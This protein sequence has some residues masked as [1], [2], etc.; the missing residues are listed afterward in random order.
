MIESVP[1]S[2]LFAAM[3]LW[4]VYRG[5]RRGTGLAERVTHVAHAVMAAA[6][7]AMCWPMG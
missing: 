2:V 5:A 6:M 3:G 1:L 4:F 7:T